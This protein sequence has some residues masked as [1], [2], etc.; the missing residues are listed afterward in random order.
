M[1][2]VDITTTVDTV[3]RVVCGEAS[4]LSPFALMVPSNSC[5]PAASASPSE[6]W[7]P[8]HKM[9]SVTVS[10]SASDR[11]D[12]SVRCR[13]DSVA[14]NEPE[15]GQGDGDMSPD[16]EITGPLTL[17]LRAERS[18]KGTGRVYSIGLRCADASGNAASRTIF[19]TVPKNR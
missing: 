15:N 3:G 1:A 11:C 19:V 10:V 13:I 17:K 14:S 12:P 4:S 7:P 18:G 2:P 5:I 6:L 9:T 16:W 8:N